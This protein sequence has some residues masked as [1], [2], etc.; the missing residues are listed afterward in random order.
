MIIQPASGL[1][2]EPL[3][4]GGRGL[5]LTPL[6][7]INL[8]HPA[9]QLILLSQVGLF[10]IWPYRLGGDSR[11]QGGIVFSIGPDC[12][13]RVTGTGS[14]SLSH[15]LF[16]AL[17]VKAWRNSIETRCCCSCSWDCSCCGRRSA[18]FDLSLQD[19]S[20]GCRDCLFEAPLRQP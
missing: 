6:S 7:K 17:I 3:R 13:V 15:G 2:P 4:G 20:A 16:P 18:P 8:P 10:Y 19:G 12:W 11:G 14:W 5:D 9:F 1:D